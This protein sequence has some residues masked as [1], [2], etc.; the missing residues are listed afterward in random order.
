M[1]ST[2]T[3]GKIIRLVEGLLKIDFHE[4]LPLHSSN[5]VWLHEFS[6]GKLKFMNT[7]P[8]FWTMPSSSRIFIFYLKIIHYI[9]ILKRARTSSIETK[10]R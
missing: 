1:T 9:Y 2:W 6:I 10:T 5:K 7:F 4:T 3:F 8:F